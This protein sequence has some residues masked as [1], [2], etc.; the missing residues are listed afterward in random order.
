MTKIVNYFMTL[1]LLSRWL[2]G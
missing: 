1:T 2:I